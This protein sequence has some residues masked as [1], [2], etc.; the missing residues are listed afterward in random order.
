[1]GIASAATGIE[2]VVP[3]EVASDDRD[4]LRAVF[5]RS[6]TAL[7]R[8]ILVRVRGNRET[9]DELLQQMCFEAM[10]S[11]HPP[12]SGEECEAWLR[13]IA[14]NLIR[15]H[16]RKLKRQAG[17]VSI[18]NAA[19]AGRLAD[20]LESSSPTAEVLMKQESA[21]QLLLAITSLP[22]ADQ[23]LIFAYYFDGRS[24]ADLAEAMDATEKSIEARLYRARNRL[25]AALRNMERSGE[26]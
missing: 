18:D 12:R 13:G 17:V 20:E 26:P 4:T 21:D 23:S 7:Y 2:Q 10:C 11:G 16:W 22:A 6:A 15:R 19:A 24:Q 25:R 3:F 8:F 1:M 5:N 14:R 9:A